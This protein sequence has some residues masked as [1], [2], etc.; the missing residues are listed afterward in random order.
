MASKLPQRKQQVFSL[1]APNATSVMLAGDFTQWREKA[2]ELKKEPTGIWRTAVEL[3][4]GT[5]RYRFIVDG[6]WCDDPSCA[7]YEPNPY[8]SRDAVVR[9]Q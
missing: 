4:P 9:I 8:G 1:K 3:A 2:I 5:H 6:Q 7:I